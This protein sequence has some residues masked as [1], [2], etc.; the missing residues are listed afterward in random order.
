MIAVVQHRR[1]KICVA[2]RQSAGGR[3][4]V[5]KT[6]DGTTWLKSWV[7]ILKELDVHT[8]DDARLTYPEYFI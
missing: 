3:L 5:W 1:G 7:C 4:V 8:I 6:S 2:E